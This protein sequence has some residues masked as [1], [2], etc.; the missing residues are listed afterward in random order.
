MAEY[1]DREATVGLLENKYQDMSAMPASYY[2]G[3][4]YALNMLKQI[5]SAADV[6]QVVHGEWDDY[7][8]GVCCSICGISLF[9]QDENNNWGI[10]PSKFE[11]CPNCGARMDGKE[12][13][14]EVSE[15]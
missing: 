9:H 4:Q 8:A 10:E 14:N 3:F 15:P 2:A 12:P 7:G 1:I 6:Q 11:F 13:D 5:S